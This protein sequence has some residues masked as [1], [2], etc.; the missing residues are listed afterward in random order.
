M[1]PRKYGLRTIYGHEVA[2]VTFSP[3]STRKEKQAKIRLQAEEA[4]ESFPPRDEKKSTIKCSLKRAKQA[5]RLN[6][7][8]G[9]S[10]DSMNSI[11]EPNIIFGTGDLLHFPGPIAHCVSSDFQMSAGIAQQ[12]RDAYPA[13]QATLKSIG[14]PQVG[15]SVSMHIPSQNKSIFIFVTKS[16]YFKK[17]SIYD[18]TRSLRC[19]KKQLI[20]QGIK[21]IALPKIGC[22]LG[23]LQE[24]SVFNIIYDIFRRSDIKVFIYV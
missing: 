19:M 9:S 14:T 18:L 6:D 22:G 16:Q 7:G 11:Q 17:P 5:T 20:E 15:A 3:R 24:Q 1:N 4:N 2:P 12:I 23:K 10:K 8:A 21:Q 13:L